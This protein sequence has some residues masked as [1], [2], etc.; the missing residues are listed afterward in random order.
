MRHAVVV[1]DDDGVRILDLS[2]SF[3]LGGRGAADVGRW[4]L[5]RAGDSVIF[6]AALA[7]DDAAGDVDELRRL[8]AGL[9]GRLRLDQHV[10]PPSWTALRP[11]LPLQVPVLLS[12]PAR[13]RHRPVVEAG[14]SVSLAR[15]GRAPVL[16][17]RDERCDVRVVDDGV[18]RVHAALV[19]V[20]VDGARR[21][22][23]VDV[24]STNGTTVLHIRD[25]AIHEVALGPAGRGQLVRAGDMVELAGERVRLVGAVDDGEGGVG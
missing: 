20:R 18:S 1:G 17:G 23:V 22:M 6:A 21:V 5:A 25:G 11:R 4:A 16:L 14:G 10:G 9:D 19:P 12:A 3:G 2:S 24:G 7:A 8:C 13:R 15:V